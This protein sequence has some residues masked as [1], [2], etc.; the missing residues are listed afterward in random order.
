[1]NDGAA[2]LADRV[3]GDTP[4]RHWVLS[5]PPPLRYL[6]AYDATLVSDV[7]GVFVAAMFQ[8]LR[9]KAKDVLGLH[10]VSMAHPGAVTV[11]QRSSSHLALN[12][13]CPMLGGLKP[14]PS[15]G[16]FSTCRDGFASRAESQR[17]RR[18]LW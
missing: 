4:I 18:A 11:I 7:L 14:P 15:G 1:M 5:L 13:H 16:G 10:S 9:W 8:S 2:F 12:V 17:S 6:L 3:I